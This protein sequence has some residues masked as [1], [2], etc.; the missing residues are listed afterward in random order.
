MHDK[1][2]LQDFFLK[3]PV[4]DQVVDLWSYK[5]TQGCLQYMALYMIRIIS[6]GHD[7]NDKHY[8]EIRASPG[9]NIHRIGSLGIRLGRHTHAPGS[10][11]VICCCNGSVRLN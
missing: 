9:G 5:H 1:D 8:P 7:D 3:G 10:S 2:L 6:C 11:N 4:V